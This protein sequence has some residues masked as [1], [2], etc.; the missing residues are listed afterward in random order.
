M[1]ANHGARTTNSFDSAELHIHV[2]LYSYDLR[3]MVIICYKLFYVLQF[4]ITRI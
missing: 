3:I 4:C 2:Q 1:L